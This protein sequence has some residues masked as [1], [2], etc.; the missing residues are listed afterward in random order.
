M[1]LLQENGPCF[2]GADSNSTYL[3]P[4]SWNNEVNMLYIDQ[5][6]QVGYS[7]D[8]LTNGTSTFAAD[9]ESVI[10]ATNFTDGVPEQNNTFFVGTF[11]SQ[12]NK[13]TANSTL[14]AAHALWHFAQTWF[15]EF[16]E[17][18]PL[19]DR[20][21]MWAESYGGHYGPNFFKFFQEQNQKILNGTIKE[22]GTKYIHL[23]TLGVVNGLLDDAIQ[24]PFYVETAYNNVGAL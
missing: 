5:P 20:I 7:Y 13:T 9:Y 16:P 15:F 11:G 18:K 1:G 23:D 14:H 10:T 19:D 17:Y 12:S 21:S 22:N 24:F 6:S 3:N 4:W 8:V 2:I